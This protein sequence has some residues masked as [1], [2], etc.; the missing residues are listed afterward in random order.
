MME[1]VAVV[2]DGSEYMVNPLIAGGSNENK[3]RKLIDVYCK[4]LASKGLDTS[5][6]Y[7]PRYQLTL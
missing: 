6:N 5:A 3:R 7:Y 2:L 4:L 1:A